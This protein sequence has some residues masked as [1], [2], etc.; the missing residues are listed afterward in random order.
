MV[1]VT[2]AFLNV[3]TPRRATAAGISFLRWPS[4]GARTPIVLLHG[5]GSHAESWLPL[6]TAFDQHAEIIAWDAPGYGASSPLACAQARPGDFADALDGLL[7]SIGV[8]RMILVGHSLGALVAA[9]FAASRPHQVAAV[10]LLSPASGYGVA[11][12]AP[13]PP[14]VQAR[15]DDLDRLGPERFAAARAS[16]LVY[17]AERNA[18][19]VERIRAGMAAV[20]QPGYGQAA[21]ALAVG[22]LP[23]DASRIFAPTLVAVG[24]E[25]LVTP[26]EGARRIH[27][28]L[29]RAVGFFEAAKVGHALPQ[30]APEYTAQLLTLLSKEIDHG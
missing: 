8:T 9:R 7:R 12:G 30:Q 10:G 27:A 24:A 17:D 6:V 15:M 29:P 13:L 3:G 11:P 16:G 18:G 4:S 26:P 5:I 25:D 1:S 14:K 20:Q 21:R 28:L 23:A 2:D 19:L 22:D